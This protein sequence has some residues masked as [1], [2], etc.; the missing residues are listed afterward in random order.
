MRKGDAG[1]RSHDSLLLSRVSQRDP[2]IAGL[3]TDSL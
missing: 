2:I 3:R 1:F